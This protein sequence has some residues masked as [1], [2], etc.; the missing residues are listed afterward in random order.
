MKN[1]FTIFKEFLRETGYDSETVLEKFT[2]YHKLLVAANER[3]NLISRQTDPE[4]IWTKHFYDSLLPVACGFDLKDKTVLDLG[5]GGGLPGIPLAILFA[6]AEF[7]LMDS[8]EKK[9]TELKK[10]IKK[11][12]LKNC[13]PINKRLEEYKVEELRESLSGRCGFDIAVCRSVKI[14]PRLLKKLKEMLNPDGYILLY[15]GKKIEELFLLQEAEE[16][17]CFE[18]PWRETSVLKIKKKGKDSKQ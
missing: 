1:S 10:I 17:I 9:I 7:Y 16:N 18:L 6:S 4:E 3:V 2:L 11:L 5:S 15:K 8:R 14:T 12:D 13:Y